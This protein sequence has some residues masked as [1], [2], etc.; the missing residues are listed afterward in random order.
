MNSPRSVMK[1]KGAGGGEFL[2]PLTSHLVL[3]T[4]LDSQFSCGWP[5]SQSLYSLGRSSILV[6]LIPT[7]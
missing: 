1:T 3:L 7:V 4:K 6:F 5:W 2:T